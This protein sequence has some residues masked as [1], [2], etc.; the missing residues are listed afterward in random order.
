MSKDW[1][2]KAWAKSERRSLIAF[3][4]DLRVRAALADND[5]SLQPRDPRN[6]TP[7]P[8]RMPGAAPTVYNVT[9]PLLQALNEV[10]PGEAM[11]G[12]QSVVRNAGDSHTHLQWVMGIKG[13]FMISTTIEG[14][15]FAAGTPWL[16]RWDLAWYGDKHAL[17]DTKLVGP[18]VQLVIHDV[19]NDF[20]IHNRYFAL[21]D[22]PMMLAKSQGNY[23][24]FFKLKPLIVAANYNQDTK[25]FLVDE[26]ASALALADTWAAYRLKANATPQRNQ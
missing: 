11:Q 19:S 12:I 3:D 24:M 20:Q 13:Q 14:H 26:H 23:L 18:N 10:Y 22:D 9:D 6:V 4:R 8:G 16:I 15:T 21:A 7:I 2:T 5:A 17:P 1:N 25:Q